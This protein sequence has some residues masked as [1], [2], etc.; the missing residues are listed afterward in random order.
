MISSDNKNIKNILIHTS[1]LQFWLEISLTGIKSEQYVI[2]NAKRLY[3]QT[4]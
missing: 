1:L 2:A 3:T 4:N